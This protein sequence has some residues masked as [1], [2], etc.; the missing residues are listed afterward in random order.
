MSQDMTDKH[1]QRVVQDYLDALLL[2][3]DEDPPQDEAEDSAEPVVAE[4]PEPEPEPEPEP[5]MA[6]A[7][8][9]A[10]PSPAAGDDAE[11]RA[12]AAMIAACGMESDEA[13]AAGKTQQS[14]E[15]GSD[16][17]SQ[18][19]AQMIAE[20][21]AQAQEASAEAPCAA[22]VSAAPA[23]PDNPTL[24]YRPADLGDEFNTVLVRM[25]G[26]RLAV[27]FDQVQAVQHLDGLS[28]ALDR[29][30]DW[31]L[32]RYESRTGPV[33]V[34]DTALRMIPERY[35]PALARYREA[36]VLSGRRWALACDELLQSLQLRADEVKWNGDRAS[37]PWLLGTCAR[38][39]CFLVDVP[40]LLAQFDAA[41]SAPA[42]RRDIL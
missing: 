34:V 30:H 19:D 15:D 29:D 39:R 31:V 14:R 6:V 35:D 1:P 17:E 10:Q 12:D 24:I 4:C 18:A 26:L 16:A 22:E 2:D 36:L 42:D 20:Y 3:S 21:G 27:P 40:A 38:E 9:P 41:I 33:Q 11:S 37:R 7:K 5:A 28:L 8:E 32:G 23:R 13:P 25:H